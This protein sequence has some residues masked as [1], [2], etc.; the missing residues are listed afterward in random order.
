MYAFVVGAPST[1]NQWTNVSLKV[2]GEHSEQLG[3]FLSA[4]KAG[5]LDRPC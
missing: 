1:P 3:N 4:T 2:S 5:R